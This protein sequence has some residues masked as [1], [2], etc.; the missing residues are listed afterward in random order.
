MLGPADICIEIVSEGSQEI[1]LLWSAPLPNPVQ[2]LAL[3]QA[4]FFPSG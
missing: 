4:M 1:A 2:I 3:V